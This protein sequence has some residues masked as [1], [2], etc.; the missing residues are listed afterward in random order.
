MK[1]LPLLGRCL[2]VLTVALSTLMARAQTPFFTEWFVDSKPDSYPAGKKDFPEAGDDSKPPSSAHLTHVSTFG[3]PY[4]NARVFAS[5]QEAKPDVGIFPGAKY[6]TFLNINGTA[7]GTLVPVNAK[8]DGPHD[9]YVRFTAANSVANKDG[10]LLF[11]GTDLLDINVR[12]SKLSGFDG[13]RILLHADGNLRVFNNDEWQQAV[14]IK[15]T[16][17][18]ATGVFDFVARDSGDVITF[19]VNGKKVGE[20]KS[21]NGAANAGFVQVGVGSYVGVKVAV[22]A[23]TAAK[24]DVEPVAPT[25]APSADASTRGAAEAAAVAVLMESFE[26][27][28]VPANL[29]M[30]FIAPVCPQW[31]NARGY[32]D[33]YRVCKDRPFATGTFDDPAE[34]QLRT[35]TR[36]LPGSALAIDLLPDAPD[37]AAAISMY[38]RYFEL[39][40]KIPGAKVLPLVDIVQPDSARPIDRERYAYEFLKTILERY[41]TDEHWLRFEGVPVIVDYNFGGLGSEGVGRVSARLA[42]DGF[43]F[44]WLGDYTA[45]VKWTVKGEITADHINQTLKYTSGLF[46]FCPPLRVME[47]DFNAFAN[48]DAVV[49]SFGPGRALGVAT[50]PGH[51]SSRLGQRNLVAARG[52]AALRESL[53]AVLAMKSKPALLSAQTWNDHLEAAHFEPSY[54]HTTALLEIV[55][56]YVQSINGTPHATDSQPHVIVSYPKTVMAGTPVRFELLNLHLAT[57]FGTLRA[58]LAVSDRSGRVLTQS[59]VL[60]DGTGRDVQV[61][62]WIPPSELARSL[63]DI[64]VTIDAD[65]PTP[66]RKTYINLPQLPVLSSI[67]SQILDPLTYSVPLHRLYTADR[68]AM[69]FNG[70]ERVA[71][72]TAPRTLSLTSHSL[73]Q[74]QRLVGVAYNRSG[75]VINEPDPD[76]SIGGLIDNAPSDPSWQLGPSMDYYSALAEFDDGSIAYAAGDLCPADERIFTD[77]HFFREWEWPIVKIG[78]DKLVDRSGRGQHGTLKQAAESTGSLPQ[79]TRIGYLYDALSFDG[80]GSFV[81]I[82]TTAYPAGPL[83]VELLVKPAQIGRT[84]NLVVQGGDAASITLLDDGTVRLSRVNESRERVSVTSHT[85]LRS[86]SWAYIVGTFDGQFLRLYVDGVLQGEMPCIGLRSVESSRLGAPVWVDRGDP[87]GFFKGMVALLRVRQ[88]ATDSPTIETDSKTLLSTFGAITPM[89]ADNR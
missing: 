43:K 6:G 56:S 78:R 58:T 54:K 28:P 3:Q 7:V 75:M 89:R 34:W 18:N 20:F 80:I 16:G 52:T 85:S 81:E 2:F 71:G 86:D 88:G 27:L 74:S 15:D 23:V 59:E 31:A 70:V 12:Q 26:P 5:P 49:R 30:T 36:L 19:F 68:V 73:Q 24:L 72:T 32:Y 84:Q 48:V 67:D 41:G 40:K 25:T 21:T 77:Y 33:M 63:V 9:V 37:S 14:T 22:I 51:Y 8:T 29:P 61:I 47:G 45:N 55:A 64:T 10:T 60:L 38:S 87:V 1:S 11:G 39:A 76:T 46:S 83:T 69:R 79:W 17:L 44:Y 42:A 53:D 66:F 4:G 35:L 13:V 50:A 82:P 65:G 57:P 62:D